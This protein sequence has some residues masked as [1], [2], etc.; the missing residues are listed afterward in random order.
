MVAYRRV[1]VAA[2]ENVMGNPRRGDHPRD[3]IRFGRGGR[4]RAFFRGGCGSQDCDRAQQG[5]EVFGHE[6]HTDQA[7]VR[8]GTPPTQSPSRLAPKGSGRWMFDFRRTGAAPT[9]FNALTPCEEGQ[10]V[11]RLI[12]EADPMRLKH[13]TP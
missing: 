6:L 9:T 13:S 1:G 8:K 11:Q 7:S 5:G 10:G 4:R 12:S 3:P 2:G